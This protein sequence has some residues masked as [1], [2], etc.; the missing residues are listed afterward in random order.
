MAPSVAKSTSHTQEEGT[1]VQKN[2]RKQ[3][4][5]VN[6]Q[7]AQRGHSMLNGDGMLPGFKEKTMSIS[8]LLKN[9]GWNVLRQ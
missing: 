3:I 1:E 9:N 7:K 6:T 8:H 2:L 5:K 4:R